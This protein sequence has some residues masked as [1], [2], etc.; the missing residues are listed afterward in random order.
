[1]APKDKDVFAIYLGYQEQ[2]AGRESVIIHNNTFSFT[3]KTP[4][5][6]VYANR[7]GDITLTNNRFRNP[8]M[9]L[10]CNKRN[11]TILIRDNELIIDDVHSNGNESII[12]ISGD[13]KQPVIIKDNLFSF[14][15][16][17]FGILVNGSNY[18]FVGNRVSLVGSSLQSL[19]RG[20]ET[21][22]EVRE[23]SFSIDDGTRLL[24]G[25]IIGEKES[26]KII[27]KDNS[28][29]NRRINLLIK[30]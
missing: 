21:D 5:M 25:S 4:Y 22:I 16:S 2:N 7:W 20:S 3:G 17:E 1:M 30:K 6:V 10:K 29:D 15:N 23:N 11:G 13:N 24:R 8:W 28:F 27:V 14:L 18:K 12:W 19:L 9:L 26:S